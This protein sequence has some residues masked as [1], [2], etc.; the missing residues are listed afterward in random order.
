FGVLYYWLGGRRADAQFLPELLIIA[1]LPYVLIIATTAAL[2]LRGSQAWAM[3][4]F[5]FIPILLVSTLRTPT[6]DQL[7][8]L[9]R[10]FP[11]MLCTIPV[12]GVGMLTSSFWQSHHNVVEPTRE[13][14]LKAASI[15]NKVL[16]RPLEVTAGD[17]NI[18]VAASLALSDHPWAWSE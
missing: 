8:V 11:V 15:W 7:S 2:G 5:A 3:P 16:D 4:V 9:Y 6:A 12:V 1:L 17:P 10:F 18:V 13:L 14:A